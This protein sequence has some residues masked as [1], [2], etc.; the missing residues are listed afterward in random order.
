M[1]ENKES[2]EE[3]VKAKKAKTKG[4]PEVTLSEE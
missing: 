4:D 2:N 1:A 3:K